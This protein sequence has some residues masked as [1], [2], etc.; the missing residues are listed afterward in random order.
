MSKSLLPVGRDR[1]GKEG[2]RERKKEEKKEGRAERRGKEEGKR[3]WGWSGIEAASL[4]CLLTCLLT[5]TDTN[6]DPAFRPRNLEESGR[7][8][9]GKGKQLQEGE[10]A[11]DAGIVRRAWPDSQACL[12]QLAH[13][14]ILTQPC[15]Q[16][17]P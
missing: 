6:T 8:G 13:K 11:Q 5:H 14:E 9:R 4:S 7:G 17:Q 16:V 3:A 2:G 15:A 1:G 12:P 10:P